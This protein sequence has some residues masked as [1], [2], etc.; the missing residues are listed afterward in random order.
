M[1][2]WALFFAS[3]GEGDTTEQEQQEEVTCL[4]DNTFGEGFEFDCTQ[5]TRTLFD[6]FGLMDVA[7]QHPVELGLTSDGTQ[8]TNT[9]S[10]V[11]A[12]LKLNDMALCHPI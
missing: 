8:L 5:V 1:I 3:E 4:K 7:K 10:H 6:A 9:I 11:A 12:G 2:G